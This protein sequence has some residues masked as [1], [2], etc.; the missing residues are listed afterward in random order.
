MFMGVRPIFDSNQ[1]MLVP[2]HFWSLVF[3]T[4]GCMVGS[5]LNVCVHRMPLGQSIVTPGS[6]CP[7]CQYSIPWYLNIPLL[8]WIYLRGK[9]ANCKAPISIRYFFVELLTGLIFLGL[10]L[11]YGRQSPG[12]VLVYCI[13]LGGFIVATFIDFEHF[14]IPDEITLGG[15]VVGFVCSALVPLLHRAGNAVQ[16]LRDSFFGI[17]VGGGLIYLILRVGK[18]LFGR[19]KVQLPAETVVVFTETSIVFGDQIIPF[20]DLFYRKGDTI[21]LEARRVELVDRC[22]S[23]ISVRLT[24]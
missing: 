23:K 24:P 13:L 17:V 10:W 9:C 22:Y 6:H 15:I 12:L 1:W 3:F 5:F 2:F 21:A 18:L 7:H 20:E 8:T 14:I 16:S 11:V 4:F 19:K